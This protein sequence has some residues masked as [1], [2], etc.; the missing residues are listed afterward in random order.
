MVLHEAARELL[1]SGPIAHVVT[2][3]E[4]G[5]PHVTMAWVDVDGDDLLFATLFDQR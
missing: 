3:G 1:L 2:L 4:D 5:S